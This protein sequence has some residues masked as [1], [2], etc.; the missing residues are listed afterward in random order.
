[1]SFTNKE[2]EIAKK[3]QQVAGHGIMD[4]LKAVRE[5]E[6]DFDKAVEIVKNL[7]ALQVLTGKINCEWRCLLNSDLD[8]DS[9]GIL[10][11]GRAKEFF[12]ACRPKLT[13]KAGIVIVTGTAGFNEVGTP[14][15]DL[16]YNNEKEEQNE[17]DR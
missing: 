3:V 2:R 15:K 12:E 4:C 8:M 5:A 14:F 6:G 10:S 16:F 17:K 13:S 11:S 1:M 9:I 7:S